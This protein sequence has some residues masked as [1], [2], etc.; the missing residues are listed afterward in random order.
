MLWSDCGGIILISSKLLRVPRTSKKKKKEQWKT[1]FCLFLAALCG[2]YFKQCSL[3]LPKFSWPIQPR[4]HTWA[5]N[6]WE[7][8]VKESLNSTC[9]TQTLEQEWRGI[10]I[11]LLYVSFPHSLWKLTPDITPHTKKKKKKS[12]TLD[13]FLSGPGSFVS[14][15]HLCWG[16]MWHSGSGLLG[17][18]YPVLV[19]PWT[20][21][22]QTP[23]SMEFYMESRKIVLILYVGQ[24]WRRRYTDRFWTQW[25]K[26]R[27]GWFERAVLKHTLPY[28]K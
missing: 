25:V 20:V 8:R 13:L 9:I 24:Q 5:S 4:V 18:L 22:C 21:A 16:S 1:T 19:T 11:L 7:K 17:K 23:L 26:E 6:D 15:S 10:S 27:V 28:A 14:L 2:C 12:P 3:V